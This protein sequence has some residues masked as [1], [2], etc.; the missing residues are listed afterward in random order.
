MD[1]GR[2]EVTVQAAIPVSE[3]R[4]LD[5]RLAASFFHMLPESGLALRHIRRPGSLRDAWK[6]LPSRVTVS[7]PPKEA[8]SPEI[9]TAAWATLDLL[10]R[11]GRKVRI[12]RLPAL[13]DIVLGD[14]SF[15]A[16]ALAKRYPET[17]ENPR[18]RAEQ[19]LPSRERNLF[20]VQDA[21]AKAGFIA[22]SAPYETRPLYLLAKKWQ[23]LA[24]GDRYNL[25]PLD[26]P[27]S[28]AARPVGDAR[29]GSYSLP[30]EELGFD[31][32]SRF[33]GSRAGW[34]A[35]VTPGDL[36]PRTRPD[37]LS[38]KV[39]VPVGVGEQGYE[40]YVYLNDVLLRAKRLRDSGR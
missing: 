38:F 26:Y 16:K 37:R 35:V 7:L 24:A 12:A 29:G 6:L 2:V 33:I 15:L 1:D 36:P 39:I 14:R 17:V 27:A 13:G 20:L 22:V 3:D 21:Q 40:A 11:R 19:A 8:M 32:S 23:P 9:F 30:L 34:E 28:H 5:E 10:H 25:R 31:T 18:E 4:C